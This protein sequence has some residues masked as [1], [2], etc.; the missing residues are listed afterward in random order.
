MSKDNLQNFTEEEKAMAEKYHNMV[1]AFL[2]SKGYDLEEFYPIV[3]MGYLKAVQKYC[4]NDN[5]KKWSFSAICNNNMRREVGNYFR[6]MNRQKRKPTGSIVS[7]DAPIGENGETFDYY[8]K[9]DGF[10]DDVIGKEVAIQILK[11][12]NNRQRKIVLLKL[13][14]YKLKEI[15]EIVGITQF[16]I[17]KEFQEVK[18][19]VEN[20]GGY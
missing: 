5:L 17:K 2:N 1:Y 8:F 16:C 9:R 20:L 6:D 18:K 19:I 15:Q 12:L 4:R 3:V 14:G 10:E 13:R 7:Y 11:L